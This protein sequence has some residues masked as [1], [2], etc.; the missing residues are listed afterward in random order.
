MTSAADGTAAG[1][2]DATTDRTAERRRELWEKIK[3]IRVAMLT[4]IGE[5]GRLYSR[6][7][8]TQEVEREDGLWFFTAKSS[9]KSQQVAKHEEVNVSYVDPQK[10]VYVSVAGSA[11]IVDDAEKERELWNPMN[12]AFFDGVVD[13]E[14]V[15]LHVEPERAEFWDAPAGTMRQLFNL[16]KAA[17]G[18]GAHESGENE[19]IDLG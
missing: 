13:P 5:D 15:L 19:K 12:K 7:M 8:Y 11:H 10:N 4:S 18:R 3:D 14:V 2:S 16:A 6:P 17:V 9:A 1:T